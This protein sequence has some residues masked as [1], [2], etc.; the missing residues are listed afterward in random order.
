MTPH[1]QEL[2]CKVLTLLDWKALDPA[3]YTIAIATCGAGSVLD[4]AV[5]FLLGLNA[6][7]GNWVEAC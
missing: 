2:M 3:C 4:V 1:L 5:M 7:C 6:L